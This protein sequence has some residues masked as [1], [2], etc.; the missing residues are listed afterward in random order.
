MKRVREF[1]ITIVM[2]DVVYKRDVSGFHESWKQAYE[3]ALSGA[4]QVYLYDNQFRESRVVAIFSERNLELDSS[5]LPSH[6]ADTRW[7]A[8]EMPEKVGELPR[9]FANTNRTEYAWCW[10]DGAKLDVPFR[11]NFLERKAELNPH[12]PAAFGLGML[13]ELKDLLRK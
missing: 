8:I 4:E 13:A 12:G 5:G 10:V 11:L 9:I 6:L 3:T 2:P 1:S 7:K